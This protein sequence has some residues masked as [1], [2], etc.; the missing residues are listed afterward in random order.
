ME[1]DVGGV[2]VVA[3]DVVAAVAEDLPAA[4]PLPWV[5]TAVGN[6]LPT[7][8]WLRRISLLVVEVRLCRSFQHTPIDHVR[9]AFSLALVGLDRGDFGMK[10]NSY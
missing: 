10:E 8:S 4:T 5:A 3:A 1:V 9:T 6:C 7:L 2:V